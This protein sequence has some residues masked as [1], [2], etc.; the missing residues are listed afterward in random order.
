M[1]LL[2][3]IGASNLNETF[4]DCWLTND[5]GNSVGDRLPHDA[6]NGSNGD[7]AV[8]TDGRAEDVI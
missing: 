3:H 4:A 2:R 6:D 5:P 1:G 8:L 7:I